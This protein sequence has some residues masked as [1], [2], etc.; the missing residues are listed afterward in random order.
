MKSSLCSLP[1]R[2]LPAQSSKEV[3]P[4]EVDWLRL[5]PLLRLMQM[6]LTRL[7]TCCLSQHS[8]TN[9]YNLRRC[10]HRSTLGWHGVRSIRISRASLK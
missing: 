8:C 9:S 3:H 1:S 10:Q 7:I 6:G 2:I 4:F 5:H